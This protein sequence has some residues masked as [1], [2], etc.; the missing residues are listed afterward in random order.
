MTTR[1]RTPRPL[2]FVYF[3]PLRYF[4]LDNVFRLRYNKYGV[5]KDHIRKEDSMKAKLFRVYGRGSELYELCCMDGTKKLL[6][7]RDLREFFM[8]FRDDE[9]LKNGA[10]GRWDKKA[11]DLSETGGDLIAYV[12]E[13]PRDPS[14]RHLVIADPGPFAVLF[15]PEDDEDSKLI[16]IT[17]YAAMYGV[18]REMIKTYCR[19]GRIPGAIKAG[20]NWVVPR[21]AAYPTDTRQ[22][23]VNR[24]MRKP[25]K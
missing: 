21:G 17:E 18:S 12:A 20:G 3:F 7:P 15:G 16:P 23:A 6:R 1:G 22:R 10:D 2:L 11:Q 5:R 19:D 25:I 4:I 9:Y 14:K 13:I 8:N 24:T